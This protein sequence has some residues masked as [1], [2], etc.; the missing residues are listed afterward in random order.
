MPAGLPEDQL[1]R[2][3]VS[4]EGLRAWKTGAAAY[5]SQISSLFASPE[6]MFSKLEEFWQSGGGSCLWK[7]A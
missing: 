2:V 5:A 4:P 3:S 6:D 7:P 1:H